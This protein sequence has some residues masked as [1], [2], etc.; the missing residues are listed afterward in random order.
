MLGEGMHK[1]MRVQLKKEQYRGTWRIYCP[2]LGADLSR[3]YE[4]EEEA[5]K[6]AEGGGY[7]VVNDS[8]FLLVEKTIIHGMNFTPELWW[9]TNADAPGMQE[10]YADLL[11][12]EAGIDKAER[13][14]D[15]FAKDTYTAMAVAT[16]MALEHIAKSYN[17][18]IPSHK[19][20]ALARHELNEARKGGVVKRITTAMGSIEL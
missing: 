17:H 14:G 18:F 20:S 9:A 8:S 11:L 5:R 16:A 15:E 1:K 4:S 12:Y 13:D 10:T 19:W 6:V 7:R 3:G 2:T